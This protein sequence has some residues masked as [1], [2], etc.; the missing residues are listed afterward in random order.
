MFPDTK[1]QVKNYKLKGHRSVITTDLENW[2]VW[3]VRGDTLHWN[4]PVFGR[5]RGGSKQRKNCLAVD[6][7][8]SLEPRLYLSACDSLDVARLES[9]FVTGLDFVICVFDLVFRCIFLALHSNILYDV[10]TVYLLT[11]TSTP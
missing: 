10:F 9:S 8:E 2:T 11:R 6:E 7:R 3:F 5:K 4:Q 1:V